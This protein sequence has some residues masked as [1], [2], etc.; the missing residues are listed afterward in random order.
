MIADV[1]SPATLIPLLEWEPHVVFDLV[2]PQR[3]GEDRFTTWGTSNVAETFG[4][5]PLE[6]LVYLSSTSVYGR[7]HGEHTDETTELDP[8]SPI[9][10]AFPSAPCINTSHTSRRCSMPS[11]SDTSTDWPTL[12]SMLPPVSGGGMGHFQVNEAVKATIDSSE[13]LVAKFSSIAKQEFDIEAEPMTP[14]GGGIADEILKAAES[15][16]ADLI[17][18]GSRG[19]TGF[20]EK[21]LG[22]VSNAVVHRAKVP[23]LTVK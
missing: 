6:A 15:S 10:Q 14:K 18:I 11:T 13:G 4:R 8:V 16:G 19:L 22:S 17:V 23:V 21:V 7:R 1:T 3:V 5:I 2:R 9:G 20:K 12:T